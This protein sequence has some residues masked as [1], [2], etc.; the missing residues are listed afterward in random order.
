MPDG[1]LEFLGRMDDQVKIRGHRVEPA[2]VASVLEEHPAVDRAVVIPRTGPGGAGK[3]LYGYVLSALAVDVEALLEF[4]GARLPAYMVPAAVLQVEQIPYSIS[5]KVDARSLP[6]PFA[7]LST[8]EPAFR[9]G[10]EVERQIAQVWSRVLGIQE[11]RID[12]HTD[13]H[14]LGGDSVALLNMLAGI[15]QEVLPTALEEAFMAR[16]GQVV[17]EPTLANVSAVAREVLEPS[18]VG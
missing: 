3:A 17:A 7:G 12:S 16:L 10:D 13:F 5:G 14:H 18:Q 15:C 1:E 8:D 2:E 6:D 11:G 9:S 4:A